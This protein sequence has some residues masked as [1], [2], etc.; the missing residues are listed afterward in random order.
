MIDE[1]QTRDSLK[2][3]NRLVERCFSNCVDTFRRKNL[4][5]DEEKCVSKC[6]EKFLKHSARASLR[7]NELNAEA[8]GMP[9]PPQ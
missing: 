1:M 2:M 3:Y 7:F 8:A 6:T 9:A 4:D 5:K